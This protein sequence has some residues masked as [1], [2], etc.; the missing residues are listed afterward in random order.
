MPEEERALIAKGRRAGMVDVTGI[1][2]SPSGMY[3]GSSGAEIVVLDG[4][5]GIG[6]DMGKGEG[7]RLGI[8]S[9]GR[10]LGAVVAR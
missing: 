7:R 6:D 1:E 9:A 3:S 5:T 2:A 10:G 8:E 4:V